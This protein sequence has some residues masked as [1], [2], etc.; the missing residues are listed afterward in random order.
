MHYIFTDAGL[1]KGTRYVDVL[2]A[3]G[4]PMQ[5]GLPLDEAVRDYGEQEI[6][7]MKEWT[8]S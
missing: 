7:S 8:E 3:D 2:D 1:I 4:N 5:Y 6:I